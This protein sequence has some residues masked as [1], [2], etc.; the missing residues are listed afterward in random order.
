MKAAHPLKFRRLEDLDVSGQI[1]RNRLQR[2][3]PE[4]NLVSG[5]RCEDSGGRPRKRGDHV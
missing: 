3:R 5:N 2:P 1:F 4:V